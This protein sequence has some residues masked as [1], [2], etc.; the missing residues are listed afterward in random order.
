MVQSDPIAILQLQEITCVCAYLEFLATCDQMAD[1][2]H[3]LYCNMSP[4][5]LDPSTASKLVHA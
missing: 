5:I 1:A 2:M 3:T 4:F